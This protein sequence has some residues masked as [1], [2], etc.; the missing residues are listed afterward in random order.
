MDFTFSEEQEALRTTARRSSTVR[1]AAPRAGDARRR[2]RRH[3]TLWRRIADLGWTGVLVP[4]RAWRRGARDARGRRAGRGDGLAAAARARGCRQ[5]W[6]AT[7]VATRLG[8]TDVLGRAATARAGPPWRSRRAAP[9]PARRDQA[10][11]RPA[12]RHWSLQGT[13]PVVL[14]GHTRRPRLRRRPRR[15]WRGH[16]RPRRSPAGELVPTWTSPARWPAWCSMAGRLAD[17]P[18]RR[19][20]GAPAPGRRRHRHRALRR[21]RRRLRPGAADGHRVRQGPGAVRPADRHLPGDPPRARRHA[22]PARAGSGRHPLRAWAAASTIR[23]GRRPRRSPR[24]S[25]ARRPP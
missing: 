5:R 11:A 13:K 10:T 18:R 9:R 17:R 15:R 4:E 3:P 19:P 16:L 12:R 6:P 1:S 23:S 20:A 25:W 24:A 14:D 7:L 21:E 22:P 2:A 8:D